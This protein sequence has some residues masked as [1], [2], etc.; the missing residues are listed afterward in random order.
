M[1]PSWIAD[2]GIGRMLGDYISTSW[3]NGKPIGVFSFA[4]R[5]RG[6]TFRQS[7]FAAYPAK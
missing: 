2:S 7:I 1:Q 6:Q 5:P 3:V 4:A